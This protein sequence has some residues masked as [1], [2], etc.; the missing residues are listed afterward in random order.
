M[1][2][3]ASKINSRSYGYGKKYNLLEKSTVVFL[4]KT[5]DDQEFEVEFKD[6]EWENI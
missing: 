1:E 2:A 4:R 6:L 3:S 5:I